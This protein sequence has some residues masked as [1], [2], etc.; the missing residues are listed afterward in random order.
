MP[1]SVDHIAGDVEGAVP[2]RQIDGQTEAVLRASP[3]GEAV[4]KQSQTGL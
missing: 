2:Y 4:T 3:W 1:P